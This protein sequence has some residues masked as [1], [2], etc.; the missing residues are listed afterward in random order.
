[1][2]NRVKI[3]RLTYVTSYIQ[4]SKGIFY[5]KMFLKG[6]IIIKNELQISVLCLPKCLCTATLVC[7]KFCLPITFYNHYQSNK[8]H[9]V[10]I[11]IYQTQIDNK[12][13]KNYTKIEFKFIK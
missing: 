1:M 6:D 12:Y 9:L 8:N 3:A 11:Q 5:K 10:T 2:W 13:I 4:K 7:N